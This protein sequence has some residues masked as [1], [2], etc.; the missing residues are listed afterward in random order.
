MNLKWVDILQIWGTTVNKY[1]ISLEG[2]ENI[3]E[4]DSHDGCTI[5][6]YTKTTQL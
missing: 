2:D 1:E 6:S 3:L 5:S 4:V